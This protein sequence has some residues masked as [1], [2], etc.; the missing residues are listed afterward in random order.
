MILLIMP[1]YYFRQ[2]IWNKFSFLKILSVAKFAKYRF[3]TFKPSIGASNFFARRVE[4]NP[5]FFASTTKTGMRKIDRVTCSMPRAEPSDASSCGGL[6]FC[7][8]QRLQTR[9]L[10]RWIL[11]QYW[12][13]RAVAMCPSGSINSD[14]IILKKFSKLIYF[15]LSYIS[16]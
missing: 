5:D 11:P 7:Q 12:K 14:F 4:I 6:D 15:Y 8:V 13:K 3:Y 10:G 16:M 2:K 1:Y 9:T